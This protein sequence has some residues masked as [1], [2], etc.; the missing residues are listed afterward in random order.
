MQVGEETTVRLVGHASGGYQWDTR[1]VPPNDAVSVSVDFTAESTSGPGYRDELVTIRGNAP[2]RATVNVTLARSW[3][4]EPIERH[5][6]TVIVDEH[7][8]TT[9]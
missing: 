5:T 8:P 1:T 9:G 7:T 3:E 6:I 2:G 4:P